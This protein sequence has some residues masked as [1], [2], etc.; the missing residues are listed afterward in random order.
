MF[1][2]FHFQQKLTT[3]RTSSSSSSILSSSFR[4]QGVM[5]QSGTGRPGSAAGASGAQAIG[6]IA[7][8]GYGIYV[9]SDV[10][11]SATGNP[12][13]SLSSHNSNNKNQDG[14]ELDNIKQ[15]EEEMR[16]QK[17]GGKK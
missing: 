17:T 11:A 6:L 5:D 14:E 9:F 13:Y 12:K 16:H 10:M 3:S 1:R 15:I 4:H 7:I 8:L 2:R